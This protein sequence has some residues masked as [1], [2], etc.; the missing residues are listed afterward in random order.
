MYLSNKTIKKYLKKGKILVS[1]NEATVETIGISAHLGKEILVPLENQTADLS[2]HIDI[3]YNKYDISEKEYILKPNDF[4]LGSTKE[5]IKTDKSLITFIDG[6][7]TLARLGM[8]IHISSHVL[9]GL[10]FSQENSV[11]EIKNMGNCNIIIRA[12]DRVGTYVF[13]KLTESIEGEKV[14]AYTNQNGVTPP[15]I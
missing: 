11:L 10:P 2:N 6:R 3:K 15:K 8:S 14:S 13:A 9:D 12:G 1:G 7:S 4:I 5:S